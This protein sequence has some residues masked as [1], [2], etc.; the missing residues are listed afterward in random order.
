MLDFGLSRGIL[1][2]FVQQVDSG[3]FLGAGYSLRQMGDQSGQSFF[4]WVGA[5][6]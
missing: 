6:H 3:P 2:G 4:H 1:F 5:N